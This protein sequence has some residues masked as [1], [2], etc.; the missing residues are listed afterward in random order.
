MKISDINKVFKKADKIKS[1][2]III[3]QIKN[4]YQAHINDNYN[5]N[6]NQLLD[7][8]MLRYNEFSMY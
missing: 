6:V 4:H 2:L 7:D 8:I 1:K 5:L 3:S